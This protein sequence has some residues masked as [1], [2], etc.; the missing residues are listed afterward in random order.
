MELVACG[1]ETLVLFPDPSMNSTI[2]QKEEEKAPE[3]LSELDH[4]RVPSS[5]YHI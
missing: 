3:M 4:Q 5:S 1:L 2:A